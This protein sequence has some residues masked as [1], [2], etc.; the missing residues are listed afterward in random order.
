[1]QRWLKRFARFL[2]LATPHIA[3]DLP[4]KI[5]VKGPGN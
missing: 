2:V 1:M 3:I 4:L 5:L